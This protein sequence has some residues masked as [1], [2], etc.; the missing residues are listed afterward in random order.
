MKLG[1]Q[2][3]QATHLVLA[4]ALVSQ[5]SLLLLSHEGV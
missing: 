3:A 1:Q 2:V 4:D 5:I